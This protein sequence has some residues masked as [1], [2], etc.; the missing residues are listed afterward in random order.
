MFR[1]L[2]DP[3]CLAAWCLYGANRWLLKPLLPAGEQFFRGHF[4]D[5]LLVPCA[6]PAV[7][8]L[9]RRLGL[10]DH[11]APPTGFEVLFHLAVWSIFF[12]LFAPLV[13][14]RATADARDIAAYCAG[15]L[16]AWAVWNR[17][18][19]FSRSFTP[20]AFS[21]PSTPR[22]TLQDG[23]TLRPEWNKR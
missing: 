16:A 4:N 13:A 11:E 19:L 10:R 23:R 20:E 17:P 9:H 14:G 22:E 2:Q 8:L 3:L 7:L 12:E 6:L 21:L 5:L 18:R 15:G 1:Y